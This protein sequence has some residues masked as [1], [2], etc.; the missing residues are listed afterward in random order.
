MRCPE[1][2]PRHLLR[3]KTFPAVCDPSRRRS[4]RD[5]DRGE[6][7]DDVLHLSMVAPP[8]RRSHPPSVRAYLVPPARLSAHRRQTDDR[9]ETRR[10][11]LASDRVRD[12]N[13]TNRPQH[14]GEPQLT[15]VSS[16]PP[17]RSGFPTEEVRPLAAPVGVTC[18]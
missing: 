2:R 7:C 5:E 3:P 9:S 13:A 4:C 6:R 1:R 10:C 14:E 8:L 17:V 15:V 18:L 16:H 11:L 12:R